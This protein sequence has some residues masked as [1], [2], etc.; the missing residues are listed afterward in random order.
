MSVLGH[1]GDDGPGSC[2]GCCGRGGSC[3]DVPEGT[4]NSY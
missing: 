3:S 4:N 1:L 2:S